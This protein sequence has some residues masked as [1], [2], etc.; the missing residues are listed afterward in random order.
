MVDKSNIKVTINF[1]DPELDAEEREIEVQ[2]LLDELK[3]IDEVETANRVLD[4]NPPKG[5]KSLGGFLIGLLTAEI[6]PEKTN[7]DR[8]RS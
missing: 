4:P 7:L 1:N 6:N 2:R 5:N 3:N 8:C